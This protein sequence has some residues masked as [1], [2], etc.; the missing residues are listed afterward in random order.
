MDRL[1]G[2]RF[3]SSGNATVFES[4]SSKVSCAL[5]L[6]TTG[7]M[8][9]ALPLLK[10]AALKL[11][12]QLGPNDSVAVYGFS[13]AVSELQ[14]FSTD[15]NAAK[16]AVLRTRASG[17]TALY[18]ALTRVNRDLAGRNGKKVIVVFTDRDDNSS[19]LTSCTAIQRA[20]SA[21]VPV[22]TIAQGAAV[23]HPVFL[24]QLAG[25]S[26][27][28]GGVSFVIREPKEIRGVFEHVSEDLMHGYLLEFQPPP[29]HDHEWRRIAV[30][31]P[32]SKNLKVRAREGYY[33]E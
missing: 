32:G 18:D 17:N 24:K 3:R 33:P 15:K 5:L 2:T 9:A 30:V 12:G 28:T 20:K 19:T 16:R 11:I 31:V 7:S 26:K 23:R 8:Q 22:Y 13:D 14:P 29:A 25:I 6:D 1:L 10:N 27:A 4:R 21:G